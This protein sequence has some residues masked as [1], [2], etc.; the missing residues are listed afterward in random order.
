MKL[1]GWFAC[2]KWTASRVA[3]GDV[4][5]SNPVCAKESIENG[6]EAVLVSEQGKELLKVRNCA[7]A[8]DDLGCARPGKDRN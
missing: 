3:K 5:P 8:K 6:S 1:S 2:E 7:G 4:R